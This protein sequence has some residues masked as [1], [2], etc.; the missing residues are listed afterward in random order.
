MKAFRAARNLSSVASHAQR[1]CRSSARVV[2]FFSAQ[3]L[4]EE[5]PAISSIPE[6]TLDS[7]SVF[8]S[9]H[10]DVPDV[11]KSPPATNWDIDVRRRVRSKVF[12][13]DENEAKRW[14]LQKALLQAALD[15]PDKE[16]DVD[17]KEEDQKSLSVGIV[18][19][20]NAGKSSLTNFMV[21]RSL[22]VLLMGFHSLSQ[23]LV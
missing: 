9:S 18:G 19:A 22:L 12:G 23:A 8:D 10:F 21:C 4:H 7:N 17:V 15:P 2:R 13:E 1:T 6:P 20:P 5:P 16:E 14:L 11:G 3:P